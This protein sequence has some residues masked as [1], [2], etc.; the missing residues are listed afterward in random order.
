MYFLAKISET[1]FVIVLG[2][3]WPRSS[4]P[5]VL[6]FSTPFSQILVALQPCDSII[7]QC[8]CVHTGVPNSL[9]SLS[10]PCMCACSCV[11]LKVLMYKYQRTTLAVFSSVPFHHV[12]CVTCVQ[13]HPCT[14]I[15]MCPHA[16]G[17]WRLILDV[18]LYHS[19]HLF[20]RQGL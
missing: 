1:H 10:F 15:H 8:C 19:P 11:H 2:P 17:G 16:C 20:L 14:C 3:D 12:L 9:F 6:G 5:Q 4:Y 18:C 7:L 13:V